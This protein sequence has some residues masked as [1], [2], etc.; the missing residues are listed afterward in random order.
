M[1]KKESK[2]PIYY[3]KK[4][5]LSNEDKKKAMAKL[6]HS[7]QFRE[8]FNKANTP[9]YIYW[10]KFK[11]KAK[12]DD[13][14]LE[15]AWFVVRQFRN[16]LA[17]PTFIKEENGEYFKWIRLPYTDEYLHKIDMYTGGKLFPENTSLT[18]N[19]QLIVRGIMEEAIASSQ[20]EGAHTTIAAAKKLIIEKKEPKNKSER[21]ILN[22]YR[23]MMKIEDE[24]KN[25]PLSIELMYEIHKTLTKDTVP[26]EEQDRLRRN[27]DDIVVEGTIK[28]EKYIA[29][30]APNEAFLDNEIQRLIKFANDE[31][32]DKFTHPIIKAI[33]LHFWLGYLHPFTDG[34][35]RLARA[36]SYWY[37][38]R[39]GYWMMMYLP[40]STIIK[41][42]PAQY[43]MAYIYSEQ[44]NLD[45]TYFYDFHIRKIIQALDEFEIYM[46]RK[47]K[48]NKKVDA[49]ISVDIQLNDRQ[50]RLIHYLLSDEFATTTITALAELNDISR[51]TAAKDLKSLENE[52]LIVSKREGKF[53]RYYPSEHL[54]Q[55]CNR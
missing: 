23:T 9:T 8:L 4:P 49:I 35:G 44:D 48:E 3:L 47:L 13:F 45:L 17:V 26:A 34:N 14:S 38:L 18:Q 15:E 55:L 11:Y 41:R 46:N 37:L 2:L 21:M 43:A 51:Q 27:N 54:K 40:I 32:G 7:D 50:K 31:E 36:L 6:E 29:H 52:G 22:N 24:Y 20:L 10:N 33:F 53:V 16:V 12:I 42:A 25:K 30:V 1:T 28:S 39:K 19:K 5:N